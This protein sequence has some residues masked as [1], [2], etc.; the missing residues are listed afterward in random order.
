[1][2]GEPPELMNGKVAPLWIAQHEGN[3]R[4][5]SSECSYSEEEGNWRVLCF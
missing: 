5:G 1:V 3:R 4:R 2:T